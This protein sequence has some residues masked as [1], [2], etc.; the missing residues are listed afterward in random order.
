[1][2]SFGVIVTFHGDLDFFLPRG[3]DPSA[4]R[5]ELKER[6]SVKDVI[7]SCGVPHPEID[8]IMVDDQF[9]N[10]SNVI[11]KNARISAYPV[12]FNFDNPVSIHLQVCHTNR[13]VA[14]VHLGGLV[15][16]LRL[17]GIDCATAPSH[18]DHDLLRVMEQED[19]ALL[20]R[21]R[22]L[23]MHRVVRTGFC[24]RSQQSDEQAVEVL[25]RFDLA[26][27]MMPFTRCVHCNTP[28]Q[29]ASKA[30]V[31]PKLEPLTR[32]YYEQFRRCP[33]CGGVYWQGSH[34]QKLQKRVADFRAKIG[35]H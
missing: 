26:D 22:R 35:T 31:L 23:L 9:V 18:D 34:F 30:E 10:F 13:F 14:D 15:R 7:E 6:T 17:L 8:A 4:V 12:D 32:I 3:V 25:R 33:G 24:P 1:M 29:N 11:D 21:D 27:A 16:N 2:D 20:T 5:R 28:L 19:R